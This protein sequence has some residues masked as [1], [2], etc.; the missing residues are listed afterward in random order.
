MQEQPA[1]VEEYRANRHGLAPAPITRAWILEGKPV[2]RGKLL[3]SSTDGM[4]F[5][6]MWDCTAGRFNW[7]YDIDE[8]I[9]LQE[10]SVVLS[11]SAGEHHHLKSGDT[12]FFPAGS[13]FEWTVAHYV[14]KIA[15]IH[16]PLSP[17]ILYA[18]RIYRAVKRLLRPGAVD[19]DAAVLL[20]G[21]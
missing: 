21:R 8:T 15:F 20:H 5:T 2:A 9:C 3:S 19:D 12:F 10:G 17:K 14:R 11:D 18:K 7:F 16:V 1:S 13:R 4:A 6:C